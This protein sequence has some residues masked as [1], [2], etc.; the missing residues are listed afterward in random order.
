MGTPLRRWAE[1]LENLEAARDTRW[2]LLESPEIAEASRPGQFLMIGYGL[3][4][5]AA[6]F[7]PRPFSV[8]WRSPDGRIGL[9]V[10]EFGAGTRR[11]CRTRPG[12]RLLLLGPLG[13]RFELPDRQPVLCVAGG[14]GL[15][16]FLFVG[17]E[18]SQSSR[19]LRI[20]YGERTGDRV[21]DPELVL[22]L[23]GVHP[24]IWTED[25][26]LGRTGLVL[27]GIDLE[28]TPLVL[29]CGPIPMLSALADLA[30]E[31]GTDLQVSVEAHMGCG[32][33]TCQGCAVPSAD[34]SWI[35]ACTE[36]PVFD[37]GRL[38]WRV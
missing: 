17:A 23:T 27:E 16:P 38:R 5:V 18:V 25:G 19:S 6:P 8:G 12:E 14:V 31:E 2:L 35:K 4:D 15:A 11:L 37:S 9:L 28:D 7:L 36:G 30:R 3:E 33:G 24:E 34:G 21:F 10:R 22:E 13:T 26:S 1:V 20:L 29:G 32:V